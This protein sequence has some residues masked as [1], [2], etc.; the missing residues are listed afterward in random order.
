MGSFL[1]HLGLL[2]VVAFLREAS[3]AS[4]LPTS[5]ARNSAAVS[6][7]RR[8]APAGPT[9]QYPD[10]PS[11]FLKCITVTEFYHYNSWHFPQEVST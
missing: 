9:P 2:A 7:F 6:S 8:R 5:S 10:Y 3:A 4:S 1:T 11:C